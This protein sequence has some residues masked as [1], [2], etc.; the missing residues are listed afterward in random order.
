MAMELI[1]F[2]FLLSVM[3]IHLIPYSIEANRCLNTELSGL[4]TLSVVDVST[5][6]LFIRVS[7]QGFGLYQVI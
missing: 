3:V 4:R 2:I 1:L 5:L 7:L 6:N